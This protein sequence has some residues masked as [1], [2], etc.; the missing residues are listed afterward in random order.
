MQERQE[1]PK[2]SLI[3]RRN[4]VI[5]TAFGGLGLFFGRSADA[6]TTTKKSSKKKKAVT[7][8]AKKS[9]TTVATIAKA[10][11]SGT[12]SSKQEMIVGW[13]FEAQDTGRRFHNPYVAVW[14]E[15]ANGGPVR[16]VHLEYQQGRGRKWLKDMKRWARVDDVLVTAG[17][18]S[19]SDTFTNATRQPGSYTVV[20]DG[21]NASGAPV[22]FGTY[23]VYVE[24]AREKGPYQFVKTQV[25]IGN[26]DFVKQGTPSGDLTAV[27]IEMKAK[28]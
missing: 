24:A 15:D 1:V 2:N 21:T 20:W 18:T 7:T 6:A 16:I 14:V 8:T 17:Q 28:S 26:A 13:T 25:T 3:S 11:A 4:V 23:D 5:G 12:F 22:P 9:G 19:S 27:T 10:S